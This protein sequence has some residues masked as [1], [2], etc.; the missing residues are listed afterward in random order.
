MDESINNR[1]HV[2]INLHERSDYSLPKIKGANSNGRYRESNSHSSLNKSRNSIQSASRFYQGPSNKYGYYVPDN[3][4]YIDKPRTFMISK[5]KN[6]DF[7]STV[8]KQKQNI[9]GPQHYETQ[10]NLLM[11]KNISI[12]KKKRYLEIIYQ[13]T[14]YRESFAEDIM[15]MSKQTPGVGSYTINNQP[16]I[17]GC[18]KQQYSDFVKFHFKIEISRKLVVWMRQSLMHC[19]YLVIILLLELQLLFQIKL[20]QELTKQKSLALKIRP[21]TEMELTLKKRD[22]ERKNSPSPVSYKTEDAW[23]K[24]QAPRVSYI[25]SKGKNLKFTDIV[26]KN[27]SKI[28]SV[29]HYDISKS[30]DK[31]SRPKGWK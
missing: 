14:I 12:Y 8:V 17:K 26:Q 23:S 30:F 16:K 22:V 29:G 1:S 24:T 28:P 6:K 15:K 20:N 5:S 31:I 2:D 25:I 11:K 18:Y 3:Y 19:R 4:S 9:P 7:I 10:V 21:E 13:I 27:S